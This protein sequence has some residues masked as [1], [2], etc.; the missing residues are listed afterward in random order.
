MTAINVSQIWIDWAEW[1]ALRCTAPFRVTFI[2][3]TRYPSR[4]IIL[5]SASNFTK[6]GMLMQKYGKKAVEVGG[7]ALLHCRPRRVAAA[8]AVGSF[9]RI[10][11]RDRLFPSLP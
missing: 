7:D 6:G 3:V 4:I 2:A 10:D 5:S 1:A 11:G 9:R 8:A